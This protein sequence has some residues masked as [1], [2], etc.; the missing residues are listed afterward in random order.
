MSLPSTHFLAHT[1]AAGPLPA[2]GG[3]PAAGPPPPAPAPAGFDTSTLAAHDF[4]VDTR[5]GFM[6]PQAPLARLPPAWDAWERALDAACARPLQLASKLG[7]TDT[8]AEQSAT[9]REEI[10]QVGCTASLAVSRR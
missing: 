3:F 5:T 4:D 9:W 10:R 6:P 7:L 2:T 8:E 1:F